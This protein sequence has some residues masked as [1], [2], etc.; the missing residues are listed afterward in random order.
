MI[1][2]SAVSQE[3]RDSL[4]VARSAYKSKEYGKAVK[5]YEAAQRKAPDDVDLSD[6]MAQSAYKAR[7]FDKAEKIYQ[8]LEVVLNEFQVLI[9]TGGVS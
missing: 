2:F 1:S 5:Y 4:D 3:W 7:E 6:E 8:Q 9:M